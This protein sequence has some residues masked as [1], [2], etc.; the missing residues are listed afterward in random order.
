MDVPHST[1]KSVLTWGSSLLVLELTS[2]AIRAE[3]GLRAGLKAWGW[4]AA[5]PMEKTWRKS[6]IKQTRNTGNIVNQSPETH[7]VREWRLCGYSVGK[8]WSASCNSCHWRCL[9]LVDILFVVF[10]GREVSFFC[11]SRWTPNTN[12][13]ADVWIRHDRNE[14]IGLQFLSPIIE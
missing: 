10:R 9:T 5:V 6:S 7:S 1:N 3:A 4:K 14:K 11:W 12:A 13:S 2:N 8:N